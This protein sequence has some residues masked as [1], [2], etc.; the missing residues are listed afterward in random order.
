MPVEAVVFDWGGT[1]TPF[2][3]I[4][5][6][7]LWRAAADRIE[8]DRAEEL[9]RAL[10]EAEQQWWRRAV[11]DGHSGSTHELMAA[12]C[13]ATGIDVERVVH[14]D[15]LHAH[16]TAWTPHTYT[17]VAAPPLLRALRDRGLK[18][19]LLSNTHWPREWHEQWLA[20]DGVLGLFDRRVYTS[21]L[22]HVKPWPEAFL[23]ALDPLGVAPERAVMVGDRKHDDIYGAQSLGMR[24]IW[25]RNDAVP[26]H[27]VT[28][29][30]EV[31][32]L[33]EVLAVVD[34]WCQEG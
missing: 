15:A 12:A 14:D 34:R 23:A 17:D 31:D 28:P 29:D 3:D 33:D 5:L 19:A 10:A 6:L 32:G 7:D 26:G 4:D 1:I 2:H 21:E 30:A 18:T 22:T 11:A 13:A 27:P 8:P 9:A 25:L 24:G 20:R 16:L